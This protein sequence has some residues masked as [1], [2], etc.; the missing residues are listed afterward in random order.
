MGGQ[1]GRA[2]HWIAIGLRPIVIVVGGLAV[3]MLILAFD[4]GSPFGDGGGLSVAELLRDRLPI[5]VEIA[6]VGLIVSGVAGLLLGLG[7]RSSPAIDRLVGLLAIPSSAL[8]APVVA[9]TLIYWLAL[10]WDLLPAFGWV[11]FRR[12][13]VEHIQ[14]MIIPTVTIASVMTI[15]IASSVRDSVSP[16]RPRPFGHDAVAAN[17]ANRSGPVATRLIGA[18]LGTLMLAL[19]SVELLLGAPGLFRLLL[20]AIQRFDTDVLVPV[21]AIVVI[22]GAI[23]GLVVD[24]VAAGIGERHVD[25]ALDAA[26]SGSGSSSSAALSAVAVGGGLLAIAVLMGL[27]GRAIGV[28]DGDVGGR[29]GLLSDGHL[30]GTDRIG[31]DLLN[32][33][34]YAM[35]GSLITALIPAVLATVGGMVAAIIG[36]SGGP[37]L[38]SVV[39]VAVDVLWWPS[40]AF[41]ALLPFVFDTDPLLSAPYLVLLGIAL[42]PV[43]SRLADRELAV[44]SSTPLAMGGIALL[45]GAAAASIMFVAGLV[46]GFGGLSLGTL[47]VQ[48][49]SELF[50][51]PRTSVVPGLAIT[52][53]LLALNLAGAGVLQLGR[54]GRP[55]AVASTVPVY[56]PPTAQPTTMAEPPADAPVAWPAPAPMAPP[57]DAP[58]AAPAPAPM[59]PPT[60]PVDATVPM[61]APV[62]A[63]V[64]MA[65]PPTAPPVDA[66]T[67]TPGSTTPTTAAPDPS[68]YPPPDDAPRPPQQPA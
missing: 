17:V 30:L 60:A 1:E 46:V 16:W 27:V 34:A 35:G 64:P 29:A 62:D 19:I 5:T 10:R 6:V 48:G 59:A 63:T 66:P 44:G 12:D 18:P 51:T 52:F 50:D 54:A 9:L 49:Q 53:L 3:A 45:V 39:G 67:A 32:T 47:F 20:E 21:I 56:A 4:N 65:A 28:P 68:A 36:R 13:A 37:G 40:I 2:V 24:V 25:P 14:W 23:I 31:R 41:L 8:A 61:A 55:A 15:P 22:V 33:T 43:A 26:P 42:L 11:S 7:A 58:V 38:R 57:A